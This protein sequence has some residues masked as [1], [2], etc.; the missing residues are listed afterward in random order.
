MLD[1]FLYNIEI[2]YD[3]EMSFFFFF[4]TSFHLELICLVYNCFLFIIFIYSYY[5]GSEYAKIHVKL[6]IKKWVNQ[7]LI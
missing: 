1:L 2:S 7:Y 5:S 3:S 4:F 6:N